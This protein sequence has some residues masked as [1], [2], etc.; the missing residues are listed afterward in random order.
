MLAANVAVGFE[1]KNATV[2]MS[3]QFCNLLDREPVHQAPACKIMPERMEGLQINVEAF[4]EPFNF[5]FQ[6]LNC[7]D[8]QS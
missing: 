5:P 1:N 4:G 8:V 2:R 7:V 3:E 6:S